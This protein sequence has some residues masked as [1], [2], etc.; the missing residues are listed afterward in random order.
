MIIA[1]QLD[2]EKRC[3]GFM[4]RSHGRSVGAWAQNLWRVVA[5]SQYGGLELMS[6]AHVTTRWYGYG[7]L[8]HL[9]RSCGGQ[10]ITNNDGCLA[11]G[12]F[13]VVVPEGVH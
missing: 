5:D 11:K 3:L 1:V 2:H 6:G 10:F 12:N 9:I 8:Q 4:L 7:E 13:E